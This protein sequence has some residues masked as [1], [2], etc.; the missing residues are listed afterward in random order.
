MSRR[1]RA[2]RVRVRR[3]TDNPNAIDKGEGIVIQREL[4]FL[5]I[6]IGFEQANRYSIK[7]FDDKLIGYIMEEDVGVTNLVMR[8]L[9]GTRR[10]FNA[11]VIDRNGDLLFKMI[12]PI[13]FLLNSTISIRDR[14]DVD[15]G[16]VKSDWHL[17]K[18]R[19]DLFLD[20]KQIYR[21]DA[22]FLSWDFS[23]FNRMQEKVAVINRN[24]GGFAKEMFADAGQYCINY[25]GGSSESSGSI[26]SSNPTTNPI[27]NPSSNSKEINSA[28]EL[29][30]RVG[31][32]N[33]KALLLAGAISIDID[34]FSRHS[35]SNSWLPFIGMGMDTGGGTPS[36]TPIPTPIPTPSPTPIPSNPTPTTDGDGP[37]KN[38]WGD[39]DFLSDEEAG[40]STNQDFDQEQDLDQED[41]NSGFGMLKDLWETFNDED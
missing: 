31:F 40:L 8:Q 1:G 11:T 9:L 15:I 4:E 17:Y 18:R 25:V 30:T 14:N 28:T 33:E 19:Y 21:I 2:N 24:F 29:V 20:K 37:R 34:Y 27:A 39:E 22:G 23:V 41:G 5:N 6:F 38:E 32:V 35:N 10:P 7:S 26:N 3:D 13:Q 36:P 12:R 16:L